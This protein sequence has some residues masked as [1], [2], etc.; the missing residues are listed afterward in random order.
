LT[1]L[2]PYKLIATTIA[3]PLEINFG[4]GVLHGDLQTLHYDIIDMHNLTP[5]IQEIIVFPNWLSVKK[6]FVETVKKSGICAA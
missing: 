6:K 5:N 3:N 1:K 4:P 2:W